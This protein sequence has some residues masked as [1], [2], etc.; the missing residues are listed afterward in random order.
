MD[1]I[2]SFKN[3]T[4]KRKDHQEDKV[5]KEPI[6]IKKALY[7]EGYSIAIQNRRRYPCLGRQL[8]FNIPT[9]PI[10]QGNN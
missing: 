10:I 6:Q 4:K 3:R 8:G 2:L 7:M 5:S 9:F 1:S